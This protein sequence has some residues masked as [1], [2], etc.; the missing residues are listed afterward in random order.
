MSSP[1][2]TREK[3]IRAM[4]RLGVDG[5]E[6]LESVT[7]FVES[8]SFCEWKENELC[9]V[10]YCYMLWCRKPELMRTLKEV[11]NVAYGATSAKEITSIREVSKIKEKVAAHLGTTFQ[12]P[13]VI[14]ILPHFA[15]KLAMTPATVALAR[16][17]AKKHVDPNPGH[18]FDTVAMSLLCVASRF[19]GDTVD[20]AAAAAAAFI[21]KETLTK[22]VLRL[23][24]NIQG[25][26]LSFGYMVKTCS[27]SVS[28]AIMDQVLRGASKKRQQAFES[29]SKPRSK[30]EPQ[31]KLRGL[32]AIPT[33]QQDDVDAEEQE[34]MPHRGNLGRTSPQSSL[35]VKNLQDLPPLQINVAANGRPGQAW[36][37][38]E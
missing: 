18:L 15:Q 12:S 16:D 11:A 21:S 34:Y 29:D 24:K 31:K 35:E 19:S 5:E 1:V 7:D 4:R 26:S 30:L 8:A 28:V 33:A 36:V 17:I 27:D 13:D 20:T 32:S 38:L 2:Q 25:S 9:C 6:H 10:I 14:E 23:E 22:A 37:M 3:V